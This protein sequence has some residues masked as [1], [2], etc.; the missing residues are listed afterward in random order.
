MP[1]G[2][3]DIVG[4][5]GTLRRYAGSL[6]RDAGEAEDLVQDALVRAY[7][8]RGTFKTG[9]NL[10]VWL[11]SI[12]HNTFVDRLRHRRSELERQ[13]Q[14]AAIADTVIDPS[15]D[16]AVRLRQI[17]DAFLELPEPQRAALHLVTIEGLSYQEAADALGISLG[18]LMSRIGRAREALRRVEEDRTPQPHLRLVG[19]RD[20][21]SG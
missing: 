7:E 18:T 11:L 10:R 14:A 21:A 12:I 16:H 6:T 15:Q 19:G 9:G 1:K 17:R 8:K 3:F 4:Q 20:D 5:L 13:G 2:A